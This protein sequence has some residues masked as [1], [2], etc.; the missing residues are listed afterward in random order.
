M[1][2]KDLEE[3]L[4]SI[5]EA[6]SD[7]KETENELGLIQDDRTRRE[8]FAM[9]EIAG[10]AV[11]YVLDSL[12]ITD[13]ELKGLVDQLSAR[14]W[15]FAK[16]YRKAMDSKQDMILEAIVLLVCEWDRLDASPKKKKMPS[17]SSPVFSHAFGAA[18]TEAAETA[19][20]I[21][22]AEVVEFFD[23]YIE[24][25]GIANTS[26]NSVTFRQIRN[27]VPFRKEVIQMAKDKREREKM[28][29][30]LRAKAEADKDALFLK[31]N[32]LPSRDNSTGILH[33]QP[34]G[35]AFP[36]R[37]GGVTGNADR[38]A[39]PYN[40]DKYDDAGNHVGVVREDTL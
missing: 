37:I 17:T 34:G 3:V 31:G 11:C 1:N 26:T 13:R 25:F 20:K 29:G 16:H 15:P 33:M 30:E 36:F 32:P 38:V 6:F 22:E 35:P 24:V 18:L 4:S 28:F 40:V 8:N 10:A 14:L 19:T 21:T 5:S 2:D 39:T 12:V 23:A 9:G 7:K 27:M